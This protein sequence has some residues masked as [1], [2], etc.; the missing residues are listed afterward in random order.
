MMK[1]RNIYLFIV[2]LLTLTVNAQKPFEELGLDNEVEL[3]TLSDGRYVEHFANDTLRQIGSVMFN[4]VT[5]KVEYFIANEELEKMNV[6][7][8]N[9]E[10]SRF[11]SLDP[12]AKKYPSY[13]PYNFVANNPLI[14]IDPDGKKLVLAGHKRK[15]F[16]DIKSLL[17]RENRKRLSYDKESGLVMFNTEGLEISDNTG[18]S[19]L[20]LVNDLVVT[21]KIIQYKVSNTAVFRSRKTDEIITQDLS[22]DPIGISNVSKTPRL[23]RSPGATTSEDANDGEVTIRKN[24]NHYEM[25]ENGNIVPKN[26]ASEVF[27]ELQENYERTVNDLPYLYEDPKNSGKEDPN[28]KGAHKV[29]ID[30]EA[31][32]YKKS[33]EPGKAKVPRK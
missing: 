27:H 32:F 26:R 24:L 28:R 31:K 9:R 13:S 10:V 25:D 29:A 20:K 3:L 6:A 4:T 19:G 18:N 7:N 8:R 5:N 17:T 15:A 21:E 14:F 23:E 1:M 11:L 12:L 33:K 2:L 30:K 16:R 22:N